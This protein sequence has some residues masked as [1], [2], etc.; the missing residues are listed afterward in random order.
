M[1]KVHAIVGLAVVVAFLALT[2]VNFLR[3][4]G[5]NYSWARG[6]SFAASGLLLVQYVLGFGL[7][8][9]GNKMT[10]THYIL[11]LAAIVPVGAEH[12]MATSD[13]PPAKK[14]RLAFFANLI[15]LLIVA[16]VYSIGDRY[17]ADNG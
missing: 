16:I 3:M 8:G 6:L 5:G 17:V 10:P 7:I 11:A 15:A 2:I 12:M 13:D 14:A 1:E 9:Q 4:R